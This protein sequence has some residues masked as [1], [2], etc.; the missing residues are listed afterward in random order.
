MKKQTIFKLKF[1]TLYP[2]YEWIHKNTNFYKHKFIKYDNLK[3]IMNKYLNILPIYYGELDNLNI[4]HI[5]CKE[6]IKN[7]NIRENTIKNTMM[8]DMHHLYLAN[9]NINS[10]RKNY[11]FRDISN[12]NKNIKYI[13]IKDRK[14]NEN[15]YYC[16]INEKYESFEPPEHSKGIIIRS[17]IYLLF[18]YPELTIDKLST[19][20]PNNKYLE[21][22]YNNK[23]EYNELL[24]N[25]FIKLIQNNKNIFI[26]YPI[27]VPILFD[28]NKDFFI[29]II[30][31]IPNQIYCLYTYYFIKKNL[32]IFY[33]NK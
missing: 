1:Y 25:E 20:I 29:K 22:F 2:I 24:K 32:D 12:E 31:M 15:N 13:D 14:T 7:I 18:R 27:L 33:K 9:Q 26:N 30:K 16:K 21:W 5:W 19:K 8:N 6:W 23:V 28:D 10:I 3:I 11:K 4:E 17:I